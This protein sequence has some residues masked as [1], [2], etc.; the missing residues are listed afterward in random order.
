[1][2]GEHPILVCGLGRSGLAAARLLRSEGKA[3]VAVDEGRSPELER[4][5]EAMEAIGCRVHLDSERPPEGQFARAVVSPGLPLDGS[6]LRQLC[7]RGIPLQSELELGW[8]RFRGRTLAVT[9]SNGKSS[10]VKAL[11]EVLSTETVPAP[12]CGNYG[13]PV[14]EALMANPSADWLVMEVS[15][16]QLETCSAFHPAIGLLLNLQPNHLDRHGDL[17]AYAKLKSRLF[18][19]QGAGDTALT[20]PNLQ[21]EMQALSGGQGSGKRLAAIRRGRS[22]AMRRVP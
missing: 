12:A 4:T 1:M 3:V 2:T 15:S 19:R 5:A 13:V 18:A 10:V 11:G 17:Q 9:G 14:C 8:S 20:P 16:F 6:F 7:E 22:T 21:E